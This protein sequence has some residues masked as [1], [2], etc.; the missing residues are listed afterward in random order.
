M[1]TKYEKL[2]REIDY[3]LEQLDLD[4]LIEI[5]NNMEKNSIFSDEFV[6]PTWSSKRPHS[7]YEEFF[8]GDWRAVS[9]F[10]RTIKYFDGI[11]D[12]GCPI[13]IETL[14]EYIVLKD[15]DFG[16][17]IIREILDKINNLEEE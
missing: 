7:K 8:E 10:N 6:F 16:H 13:E 15:K 12:R 14:T 9:H 11:G 2:L 1:L 17:E 4:Y 5:Y 3:E